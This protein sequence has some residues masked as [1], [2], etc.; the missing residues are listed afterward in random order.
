MLSEVQHTSYIAT[1]TPF[2]ALNDSWL[3]QV[4]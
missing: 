1:L 2:Y 3:S 4:A